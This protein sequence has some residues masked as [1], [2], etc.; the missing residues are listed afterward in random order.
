LKLWFPIPGRSFNTAV[1]EFVSCA[2]PSRWISVQNSAT[3]SQK[4]TC[5]FFTGPLALLTLAVRI[6]TLPD[7]TDA[8]CAPPEVILSEVFVA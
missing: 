3:V 7:V 8:I 6:T 5:P 2:V 4:L 1:P